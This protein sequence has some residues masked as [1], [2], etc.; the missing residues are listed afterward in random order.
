M[1]NAVKSVEDQSSWSPEPSRPLDQDVWSAW[2]AKNRA[3]EQQGA[4]ARIRVVLLVG[5][6]LALAITLFLHLSPRQVADV[7]PVVG[8]LTGTA[9]AGGHLWASA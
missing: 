2:L 6:L 5:L 9:I 3:E 4:A 7:Q 8:R 1:S